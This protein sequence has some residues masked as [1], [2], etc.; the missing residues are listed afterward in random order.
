MTNKSVWKLSRNNFLK[1]LGSRLVFKLRFLCGFPYKVYARVRFADVHV[2]FS[3]HF[4]Y[5]LRCSCIT[6]SVVISFDII[7]PFTSQSG[8]VEGFKEISFE[9]SFVDVQTPT[10]GCC[11]W[12]RSFLAV[13][14]NSWIFTLQL[15]HSGIWIWHCC[16]FWVDVIYQ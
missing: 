15:L 9:R 11:I 5:T 12:S 7:R 3:I 16:N 1:T 13:A 10:E 14:F 2:R 6:H 8:R 4:V